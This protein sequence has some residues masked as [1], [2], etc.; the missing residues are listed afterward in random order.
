MDLFQIK[1]AV[2]LPRNSL[3]Y[4]SESITRAMWLIW[5]QECEHIHSRRVEANETPTH[6]FSSQSQNN[7]M[8]RKRRNRK[9]DHNKIASYTSRNAFLAYAMLHLLDRWSEIAKTD[10]NA[11]MLKFT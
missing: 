5:K 11:E 7:E 2:S 1:N 8:K 6:S 4:A 10:F 3:S 9:N